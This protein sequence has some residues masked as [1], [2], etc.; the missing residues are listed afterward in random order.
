M[1]PERWQQIEAVFQTAVDLD[2]VN[3]E[4]YLADSCTHDP[5]LR[6]EVEKLLSS[7]DSAPD[8]IESPVWTDSNFLNTSAKKELS[9]SLDTDKAADGMVGQQIGVY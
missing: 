6:R 2:L 3:R 4:S 5:E 1:S 8:F 9:D 7:V